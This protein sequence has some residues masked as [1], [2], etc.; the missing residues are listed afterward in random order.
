MK[1]LHVGIVNYNTFRGGNGIHLKELSE[2]L[3][4]IEENVTVYALN[5]S[6]MRELTYF[7]RNRLPLPAR[8]VIKGINVRRFNINYK[9]Y[10]LLF[11]YIFEFPGLRRLSKFIFRDALPQLKQGP[12]VPKMIWE[13]IKFKPDI[14]MSLNLYGAHSYFCYLAKKIVKFPLVLIPCLHIGSKWVENPMIYRI[15]KFSDLIIVLTPYEKEFLVKKGISEN[16]IAVIGVGIDSYKFNCCDGKNFRR[17]N[18]LEN[19]P[20]VLFVGRKVEGKGIETLIEAMQIVWQNIPQARLVLAGSRSSNYSINY[21]SII[22]NKINA[23]RVDDRDKVIYIDN[24]SEEEK[25]EIFAASDIFALPS[26]C[27]SFGIVYLE[28]WI[29]RKPVIACK[30]SPQST[31]VDENRDGLLVEYGHEEEL[32]NAIMRLLNNKQERI[33]MGE[34][35]REKVLNS[36]TWDI[37]ANKVRSQYYKLV[38]N[39]N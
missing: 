9:A 5:I 20:I 16:K 13:I 17:K 33:S 31:I 39:R 2:S 29:H 28:A 1:I 12:F 30:N 22:N 3:Q 4:S 26:N 7:E 15:M 10:K 25:S 23:L 27:D 24:F 19:E 11:N 8:E 18:R 21:H 14:V 32:A 35:G 36:Y 38:N 34:N 6:S 37:I